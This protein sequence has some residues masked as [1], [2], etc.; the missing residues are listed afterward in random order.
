MLLILR[1]LKF[2]FTAQV[3]PMQQ[4]CLRL[5]L[6]IVISV[7]STAQLLAADEPLRTAGDRPFDIQHIRLDLD[8]SL[9]KKQI[10]GAAT[11]D[12]QLLRPLQ[13]L[14]LDA[15]GLEVSQVLLAPDQ[16]EL[17]FSTTDDQLRIDLGATRPRGEKVRVVIRYQVRDPKAGM[18]F[19]GP[20]EGEPN[21]PWMMWTQGE[22]VANHHWFPCLDHPNERQTTEIVA[23]V[24]AG[25]EV[26]SNGDLLSRK[27]SSDGKRERFHYKQS[28]PHVAYLVTLVVGEF[29]I[30]RETWGDVPV[31]YYV[32]P[33]QAGDMQRTFG[34]TK[35]MLTF[36]SER[37]GINYPWTKYAQIVVEQFIAGGM[38]NTGATTLYSKVMHD[39]RAM[40]DSSPDRLIA[41]E[42]GHQWWGDLVTCKDWSHLWL[43]EGFATFCELM[44]AEHDL[45][46]D[47][48][49]YMLYGKGKSA[50][51]D[52][53]KTRPIVD[54]H[55]SDPGSMFDA[56]A[57]PK[58]GWVLHMLR[59]QLGDDL[60]YTGLQK[61]GE[62]FRM[63][64]AETSD[65]RKVLEEHTGRNLERFFYDW[66]ARPGHPE[67]EVATEY[68]PE[69]KLAKISVKQTQ[70]GDA[71]H[72]PLAIEIRCKE[73]SGPITVDKE[74][75]EK[76]L[77]FYLPLPAAP[78]LVRIDPQ[79]AVLAELKEKKSRDLWK[80]QLLEAPT[81][82]ERIR[83]VE[84]FAESKKSND[85]ELLKQVLEQDP[86]YGVRIE[87]SKALA[88]S[89]G[90]V[91]RD[92]LIAGLSQE[93]PKVRRACA[94]ALSK[95]PRDEKVIAVLNQR[96][97]NG[98][99]S[100]YVEAAFATAFAK[101]QDEPPVEPLQRL[102]AQDSHGE[103]IRSAALRG[104]GYSTDPATLDLLVE[105]TGRSKPRSCRLAAAEAIATYF[106]RNE[107]SKPVREKTVETL[108]G[109]L[110]VDN[111]HVRRKIIESLGNMGK[112]AATARSILASVADQDP[113]DRV[114]AA[115]KTAL[116]KLDAETPATA[117]VGKLRTELDKLQ[118]TNKE[119]EDRLQKLES[120]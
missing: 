94:D 55:Y 70:K 1:F 25:Y 44:W 24:D 57:Y 100:Y 68:D 10:A 56:R 59:R 40:L 17:E 67:L 86:F 101:V 105:W 21:V 50:R 64:T 30:G 18:Y 19:F 47:E 104:L 49:D 116:P 11:I 33:E 15:V 37:F 2:R 48:H 83:A 75:T 90:D 88:K 112:N 3:P 65:L 39:E 102:L 117:E 80:T 22:P 31:L 62:K 91:S 46:V 84:H 109:Y 120:K 96:L 52:G 63:K 78:E 79:A 12:L 43:N 72:F 76:E 74:I 53:P 28:Q 114:R 110:K 54:Y 108:A 99:A 115:A 113:D 71:F 58:G 9:K 36:F 82:I 89:G 27:K 20:T 26:L 34:R 92:A 103:V 107:V 8:I 32:P 119:L 73:T 16:S 29:E 51:S 13:V 66:T 60:F 6:T 87:A 106:S 98:D 93:H 45:G 14:K 97:Q 4:K 81:V 85:R 38:E 35:N 118:K 42:L 7:I 69:D 77:T 5:W 23:T 41:H 61:Y 95:F 111:R